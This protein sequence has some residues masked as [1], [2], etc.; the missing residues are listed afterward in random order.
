MH[1][2]RTD[3][4]N[5]HY[6]MY[7]FYPL[8]SV[9]LNPSNERRVPNMLFDFDFNEDGN[10]DAFELT[11]AYHCYE[12]ITEDDEDYGEYDSLSFDWDF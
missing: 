3:K 12:E 1:Q 2:K 7:L 6:F 10:L 4:K 5:I 9:I 11:A 8:S